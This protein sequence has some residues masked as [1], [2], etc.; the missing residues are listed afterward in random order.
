MIDELVGAAA[1]SIS[2]AAVIGAMPNPVFVV[3]RRSGA[4]VA[5]A[6]FR[7]PRDLTDEQLSRLG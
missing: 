6:F 1:T 2:L 4:I 3:D 5:N 7:A